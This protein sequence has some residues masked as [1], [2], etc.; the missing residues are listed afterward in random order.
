MILGSCAVR[1]MRVCMSLMKTFLKKEWMVF[2]VTLLVLDI[3][4]S[5]FSSLG[6]RTTNNNQAL[7][8]PRIRII[9]GR[10]EHDTTTAPNTIM[11][12]NIHVTSPNSTIP[13]AKIKNTN[14]NFSIGNS[15]FNVTS[16][17]I[18]RHLL[19]FEDVNLDQFINNTIGDAG[20]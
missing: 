8:I 7:L 17:S 10:D 15:E 13:A 5:T 4:L 3:L 20:K 9:I 19:R 18:T 12:E 11:I 14:L 6:I 1:E 2:I 16:I